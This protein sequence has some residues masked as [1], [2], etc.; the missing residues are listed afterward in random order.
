MELVRNLAQAARPDTA[1][2]F[3][4]ADYMIEDHDDTI[5]NERCILFGNRKELS[6]ESETYD[7]GGEKEEEV[8]DEN[9][10]AVNGSETD[11]LKNEIQASRTAESSRKS[12]IT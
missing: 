4:I 2:S 3:S 10:N 12:R 6:M 1:P 5:G 8:F 9:F 7:S 11:G